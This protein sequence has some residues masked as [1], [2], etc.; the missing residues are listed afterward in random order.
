[1]GP[2][3]QV[4]RE[5]K[6]EKEKRSSSFLGTQEWTTQRRLEYGGQPV[7][8]VVARPRDGLNGWHMTRG[9]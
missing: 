7:F 3:C 6:K 9:S 4:E 5:I 8:G 1:M 2:R